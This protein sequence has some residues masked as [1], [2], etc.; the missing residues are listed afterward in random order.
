[1]D[2]LVRE[3]IESALRSVVGLDVVLFFRDYPDALESVTGIA[4]RTGRGAEEIAPCLEALTEYGMLEA[5]C[6]GN[7]R[8]HCYCLSRRPEMWDL[9]CRLSDEY[10]HQPESRKEIVRLLMRLAAE[11]TG[12]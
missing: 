3:F 11:R 2:G 7:D 9:V 4:L 1:M 8:Y 5:F 6:Q 12:G 10:L